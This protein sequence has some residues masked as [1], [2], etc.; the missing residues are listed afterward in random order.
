MMAMMAKNSIPA[1][2]P[3][4]MAPVETLLLPL[5]AGTSV[6]GAGAALRREARVQASRP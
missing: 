3:P 1:I 2:T 5:E 6:L 4:T